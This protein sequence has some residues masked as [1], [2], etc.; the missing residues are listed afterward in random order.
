MSV[1]LTKEQ[2]KDVFIGVSEFRF[3]TESKPFAANME[4]DYELPILRDSL[5]FDN[6][7]PTINPV[8]IHG[9]QKPYASTSEPS[10]ITI[11]FEIP[12]IHKDITGFLYN[13]AGTIDKISDTV[14]GVSGTWSGQGIKLDNK[15]IEGMAM[16]I[17]EDRKHAIL[18]KN[19]KGYSS[20]NMNDI[21]TTP[22]SFTVTATL[23]GGVTDDPDGDIV[24]MTFTPTAG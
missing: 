14:N 21:S 24:F 19:L 11:A 20:A 10:D 22:V 17:S 1:K 12:S 7:A 5:S 13:E 2:L 3:A 16:I 4:W 18:I 15:V 8:Y 23:E 9:S 6:P